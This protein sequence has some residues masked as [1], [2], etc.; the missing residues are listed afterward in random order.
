MPQIA[1]H[2]CDTATLWQETCSIALLVRN[3]LCSQGDIYNHPM[4]IY[5]SKLLTGEQYWKIPRVLSLYHSK[6]VLHMDYVS[7]R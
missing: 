6:Q 5:D 3:K 4:D 7:G 1:Q 2:L